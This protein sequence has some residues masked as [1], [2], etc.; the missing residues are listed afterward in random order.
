MNP[1][2]RFA[3]AALA[4]ALTPQIARAEGPPLSSVQVYCQP[5]SLNNCFA[6]AF[7]SEDGHLTYYL[8]NLQGSIEPGGSPFRI[9]T[10]EIENQNAVYGPDKSGLPIIQYRVT[11]PSGAP[12]Q[13]VPSLFSLEGD[14]RRD[15][16][17]LEDVS[18]V[19]D[20]FH[21]IYSTNS[22]GI[23]GCATPYTSDLAQRLFNIAQT[24]IPTG[25]DGFLRFD[26]TAF[27]FQ[28]NGG[29]TFGDLIGAATF[30][31][32]YINIQGC[33]VVVGARSGVPA[34][35]GTDCST[36]ISYASL[37]GGTTTVPEPATMTLLAT[38]LA[39]MMGGARLR[40]RTA[41]A[42]RAD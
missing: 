16:N 12:V 7:S 29:G 36:N 41:K 4:V 32:F 13:I 11:D 34:S 23:Y 40:R 39:G 25:L 20:R 14:V 17:S 30:E 42:P 31:D 28:N 15:E 18:G 21:R 35:R 8:Q 27:L 2:A 37:L 38:G 22:G 19:G 6:F 9:R 1:V 33:N 5:G 3:A 10:I 24:C 26:F